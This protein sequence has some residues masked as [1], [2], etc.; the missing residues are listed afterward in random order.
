MYV[1]VF[2]YTQ[3]YNKDTYSY[4]LF[5]FLVNTH[6]KLLLVFILQVHLKKIE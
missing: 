5:L 6:Q 3:I 2:V 4:E 1:Y